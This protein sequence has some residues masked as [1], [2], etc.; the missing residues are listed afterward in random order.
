MSRP[1]P[2]LGPRDDVVATARTIARETGATIDIGHDPDNACDGA[3]AIYTD[4]WHSMGDPESERVARLE[5]LAPFRVDAARMRRA[6]PTAVFLHC[7]PAHRGEEVT[8]EV[9]DGPQSRIFD[10]AENKL[11]TAVAILEALVGGTL[12]GPVVR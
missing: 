8:A 12:A 9:A 3:D 10:Q 4:T 11:H 5:L 6:K 1:P 2:T 7:L